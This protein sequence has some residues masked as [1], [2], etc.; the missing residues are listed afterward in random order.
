MF[1]RLNS[2]NDR[3][4]NPHHCFTSNIFIIIRKKYYHIL[5]YVKYNNRKLCSLIFR[6]KKTGQAEIEIK[7]GKIHRLSE[8][9][10]RLVL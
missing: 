6:D 5:T 2:I 3:F 1:R 4:K 8:K 7:L 10:T 9:N